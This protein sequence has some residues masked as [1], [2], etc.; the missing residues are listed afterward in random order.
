M[1]RRDIKTKKGRKEVSINSF[2][3]V[4][5]YSKSLKEVYNGSLSSGLKDSRTGLIQRLADSNRFC[6]ASLPLEDGA[7]KIPR[8]KRGLVGRRKLDN[9]SEGGKLAR[10]FGREAGNADQADK[11]AGEDEG[12]EG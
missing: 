3:N 2:K 11:L 12:K 7:I 4:S 10:G 6:G 5:S 9:G 1:M 8:R